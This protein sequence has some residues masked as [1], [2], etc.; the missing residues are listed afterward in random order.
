MSKKISWITQT[1]ICI[2]LLVA[3]QVITASFANTFI[4]GTLVNLVLIISVIIC[5]IT[6]GLTVAM[7]SPV[8]ARLLGIGPLWILIPFIML[9]NISLV[10]V[11]HII[12]HRKGSHKNQYILAWLHGAI[13]KFL[14]LYIGIVKFAIPVL[15][16]L[17]EKKAAMISAA[18]SLPQFATAL[19]GGALALVILPVIKKAEV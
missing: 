4:T 7:V 14:I 16:H 1:A 2:A 6:S 17:P 12:S 3:A 15:L 19:A 5:G 13:A 9:G 11:W 10:V 8:L 18:F